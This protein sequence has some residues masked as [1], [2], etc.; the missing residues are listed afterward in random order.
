MRK[1]RLKRI[2]LAG[3]AISIAVAAIVMLNPAIA[4]RA[5]A[6]ATA[7]ELARVTRRN[8]G[9]VV[10]AT[11]VIRPT[12]GAEVR[13]GARISGVVTRLLVRVG[14]SVQKGQLLAELDARELSARRSQAAAALDLA[15]ADLN[16]SRTELARKRK[17]GA[18][19]LVAQSELEVTERA[20]TVAEQQVREAEANLELATIQLG[21]ARIEAP[22]SGVVATVSTQ[23]GETVAASL[24]APTF[25]TLIDLKRLEVRAYVDETDIGRIQLGEKARFSVDTYPGEEFDGQVS[26]VFPQAEIRDNVVNYV[27][28]VSF[29]PPA[30]R[31]LRPEMTTAVRIALEMHDNVLS[32]PR[33]ALRRDGA[34]QFVGRSHEGKVERCWVQAGATDDTYVEILEGLNEGDEVVVGEMNQE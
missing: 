3:L 5:D 12:I 10:A 34:R 32:I 27:A 13:V 1:A 4:T 28:V 11:G 30:D 15:R 23:E 21:Y 25:V 20:C 7:S 24:A 33:R 8:I 31:I 18:D 26:D 22:I 19:N 16:Y 29:T 14:D 6:P 9:T 17:L 2:V